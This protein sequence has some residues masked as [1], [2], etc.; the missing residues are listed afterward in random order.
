MANAKK[1]ASTTQGGAQNRRFVHLRVWQ[2]AVSSSLVRFSSRT[3]RVRSGE[4]ANDARRQSVPNPGRPESSSAPY[5]NEV[6]RRKAYT[7]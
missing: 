1:M 6:R 2:P 5:P 7:E 4:A 3:H